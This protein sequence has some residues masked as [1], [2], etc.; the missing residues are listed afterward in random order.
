MKKFK[1]SLC[2][3]TFRSVRDDTDALAEFDM[4]FPGES[5]QDLAV[6]CDDCYKKMTSVIPLPLNKEEIK[7]M[8]NESRRI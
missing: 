4:N 6:V 1:C 8:K 3:K 5:H 2:K 7:G